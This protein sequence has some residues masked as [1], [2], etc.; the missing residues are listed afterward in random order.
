MKNKGPR[1]EPHKRK[2]GVLIGK[3]LK[4]WSGVKKI[5]GRRARADEDDDDD[6][7]DDDAENGA[8]C[9]HLW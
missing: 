2:A 9:E 8:D 7:D 1:R 4:K 3:Q 6:A 5:I